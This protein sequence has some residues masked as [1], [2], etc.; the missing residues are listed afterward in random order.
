MPDT[1]ISQF[2]RAFSEPIETLRKV[3]TITALNAI[4]LGVRWEGMLV[5]VVSA[6]A[7]YE[8]KGGTDNT[9]WTLFTGIPEAPEDGQLYGRK[10]GTWS[11]VS[12]VALPFAMFTGSLFLGA[13]PTIDPMFDTTEG[14]TIAK[15]GTGSYELTPTGT[16]DRDET[17]F[18]AQIQSSGT[19]EV[20]TLNINKGLTTIVFSFFRDGVLSDDG[21]RVDFEIKQF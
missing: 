12:D 19:I 6:S 3:A 2:A 1:I 10:D 16:Y 18:F 8:L 5:Y 17:T 7:T 15:I 20:E 13:T 11:L 4:P 21:N 14:W 9:F